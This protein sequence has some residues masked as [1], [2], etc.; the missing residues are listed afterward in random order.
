MGTRSQITLMEDEAYVR[1][2]QE[3]DVAQT[4]FML[5]LRRRFA[6]SERDDPIVLTHLT[7]QALRT[8]KRLLN[9]NAETIPLKELVP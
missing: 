2:A 6:S 5:T 3:L 1:A 8:L 4:E 9:E 7:T